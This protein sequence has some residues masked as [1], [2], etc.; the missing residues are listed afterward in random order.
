MEESIVQNAKDPNEVT[1]RDLILKIREWYQYLLSRWTVVL[2]FCILGGIIGSLVSYIKKPVYSATTTFVLEEGDK[3]GGAASY[4]GLASMMGLD[5]GGSGGGIFQGDNIL[6]LYKSR[7]MI[8]KS[9]LSEIYYNGHKELLV[10]RYIAINDLK[11]QWSKHV[12]LKNI[13][14][15]STDSEFDLPSVRR[16]QDSL[17]GA[18]VVDIND[19][20]LSVSKPDKKLN[21][22]VATVEST[23]EFFAKKFNE[24]I[25]KTVN[26]FYVQTKTKKSLSN[27]HIMQH[28]ADSVRLV[29]NGAIY[30]A[31]AVS[32]A[33]PNLN[34]TR[35]VQRSAPVQSSQFNAETNKLVLAEIVKNLELSKMNLLKETPLIQVIDKP[36]FPLE[37]IRIG[38]V[39]GTI[40][41]LTLGGVLGVIL[42]L[43]ANFFKGI[44]V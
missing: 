37:M 5:I 3:G 18:F 27:V 17:L 38:M 40:F 24:Q 25:V 28:K 20:Y 10:D 42:L 8:E 2:G 9:L 13:V 34:V 29:M 15:K 39:K 11:K 12:N 33:T 43:I 7:T 22:F 19:N 30:S 16:L 4:A 41:G 6:E 1:L 21:I 32:D 35:Q 44:M 23:D 36:V 26:D 31:F 14:F